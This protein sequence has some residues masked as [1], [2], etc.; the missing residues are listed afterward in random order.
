M[1]H[2]RRSSSLGPTAGELC[3]LWSCPVVLLTRVHMR[4]VRSH[5]ASEE[6][7][8]SIPPKLEMFLAVEK[9]SASLPAG[10]ETGQVRDTVLY[11]MD[12]SLLA[13]S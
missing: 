5:T 4:V 6:T 8:T 10:G 3:L 9:R 13:T 11:N 7:D 1:W 12:F 2:W